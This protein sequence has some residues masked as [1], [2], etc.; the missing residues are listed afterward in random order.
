MCS[1]IE[2]RADERHGR[3]HVLDDQREAFTIGDR[4]QLHARLQTPREQIDGF[5][6]KPMETL[7]QSA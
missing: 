6:V 5:F 2:D 3:L 7:Q 1:T 4:G